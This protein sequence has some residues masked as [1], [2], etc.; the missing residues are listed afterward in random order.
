MVVAEQNVAISNSNAS[1]KTPDTSVPA[2]NTANAA[3]KSNQGIIFSDTGAVIDNAQLTAAKPS[4]ISETKKKLADASALDAVNGESKNSSDIPHV[5]RVTNTSQKLPPLSVD[6]EAHTY[7][8]TPAVRVN[9]DKVV[10]LDS[11][12]AT[13]NQSNAPSN[14]NSGSQNDGSSTKIMSTSASVAT[15]TSTTSTTTTTTTTTPSTTTTTTTP[16]PK[17]P[18]ITYSVEDRP[19]LL[20]NLPKQTSSDVQ[21]ANANNAKLNVNYEADVKFEEQ[22]LIQSSGRMM[23]AQARKDARNFVVPIVGMIFAIPLLIILAHFAT[24]RLRDYWS[25]R[26]YR[27]MDY[28]IEEIYN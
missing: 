5:R 1:I 19:D 20:S 14:V 24:R 23:S 6:P 2:S 16:E 3:N 18:S 4:S 10:P 9:A 17:K 8:D 22:P 25:K 27:R 15:P 21:L 28:L 11:T 26:K 13:G 12:K 7:N